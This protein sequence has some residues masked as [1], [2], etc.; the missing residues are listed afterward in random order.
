MEASWQ[1]RGSRLWRAWGDLSLR[2]K[3]LLF[4]LVLV[5]VPGGVLALIAFSG[6]RAAFEREVGIQLQQTAQ[7]G[8]DAVA[9]ELGRAQSDARSW[10]RQDV[11]RDLLVG[12]LDKRVSKFLQAVTGNKTA[13]LAALCLDKDGSVIAASSGDWIGRD[14]RKWP[15]VSTLRAGKD[16]L[17]GPLGSRDLRREVLQIGVPVPNPDPPDGQIGSLILLY[18]WHTLDGT[19]DSIRAKLAALGKRVAAIVVDRDGAV[20]GGVSFDGKSARH[21]TLAATTWNDLPPGGFAALTVRAPTDPRAAVLAGV[22]PVPSPAPGWSVIFVEHADSALAPVRAV[23]ARWLAV[24]AGVLVAAL[25]VAALLA[26][27]FMRPLDE[28]TRATSRIAAHPDLE[29]PLLPV[30][31]RNEVGQLTESFNTLTTELKRSQEEAL[32]AAKFAFAGELAAM[33]AHEVRTPLS[34]MR[35]SAQ[36]LSAQTP[37]RAADN[38]E[39]V[40]TIVAEVDRVERVVTAL[41]QLSRPLEQR[42]EPTALRDVL[43]RAADFTAAHAER[44]HVRIT[45]DFASGRRAAMCDPEQMYQVVLNLLVNAVQALPRGG[46]IW[47][48]TLDEAAGMVGFEVVDDGPGIPREIRDRIFRPFV[49]GRED[50]TGLG[51]AFVERVVKAHRGSVSLRS[52]PGRGTVF[53][54][55]LPMAENGV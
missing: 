8:A 5:T 30:R 42:L 44:Q 45:C 31:S 43:S 36:M 51:L 14:L 23:R 49:T 17:V 54:V 21:S 24:S 33:V 55:Q 7:R 46:R 12:D 39:L 3:L 25:A 41:I 6:V 52:E 50:G 18:D 9:A 22:A 29:L 2:T 10:A 38:A 15:A 16:A 40:E 4:A 11:M 26:R 20:N 35:S 34:V 47:L 1:A 48:R 53:E 13:Y 28:V 19:L 32:S 37:A 27:Q